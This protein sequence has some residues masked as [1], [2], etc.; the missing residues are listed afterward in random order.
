[1]NQ[2]HKTI[3]KRLSYILR[4]RPDSVGV[5]LDENGWV[6]VDILLRAC[7]KHGQHLSRKVL[8]EVVSANDKQRFSFSPDGARIRANQGHSIRVDLGMT[9][10]EPPQRLYHG[11]V[12]RFLES[13]KTDGLLKKNRH[14]VHL[15]PDIKTAKLVGSRRGK[16]VVLVVEA[17]K[18]YEKG[19]VFYCSENGVWLTDS[20]PGEFILFP[21]GNC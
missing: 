15:S 5:N 16:P 11:T 20:V 12:E 13:I 4:H 7:C 21:D 10:V 8:E 17:A 9:A 19:H 18:M 1:M 2:K 6:D 3:S 14:H